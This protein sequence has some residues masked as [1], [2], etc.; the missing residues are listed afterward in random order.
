MIDGKT[1]RS[2]ECRHL[3]N[4]DKYQAIW[5]KSFANGLGCLA[6]GICNTPGTNTI[7]FI[8]HFDVSAKTTVTY[9]RIVCGDIFFLAGPIMDTYLSYFLFLFF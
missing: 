9:G 8:P 1:G 4:L 5:M 6:Q 2:L 7:N 3:I